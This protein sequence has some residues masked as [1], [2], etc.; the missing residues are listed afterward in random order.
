[1]I[2]IPAIEIVPRPNRELDPCVARA[3]RFDWLIFTSVNGAEI[4]LSRA[5]ELNS[6]LA[7]NDGVAPRICAIGPATAGRVEKL[8]WEVHLVPE[9]YQAEGVLEA[10]LKRHSDRIEGLSI[11]IPRASQARSLLPRE[12]KRQGARV[13]VV[14]VYDTVIPKG[15]RV[16]LEM[17]LERGSPDLITFTSSSTVRHLLDLASDPERLRSHP[18]AAIGPITA[19]TAREHGFRVVVESRESTIPGLISAIGTF[20]GLRR[21]G[22]E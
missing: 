6:R 13:E 18:C 3:H 15:S 5:L 20:Y 17:A 16:A 4:L 21:H 10:F 8:G 19:D 11:L 14:P 22:V 12:L 1:V 2:E 9:R 7:G